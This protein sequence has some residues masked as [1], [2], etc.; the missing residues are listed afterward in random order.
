LSSGDRFNFSNGDVIVPARR[1]GMYQPSAVSAVG[2]NATAAYRFFLQFDAPAGSAMQIRAVR[3]PQKSE[4][5]RVWGN[6]SRVVSA[7]TAPEGQSVR[8]GEAVGN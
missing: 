8:R 5:A 3:R 7:Q 6:R 1:R 4:N 2:Q